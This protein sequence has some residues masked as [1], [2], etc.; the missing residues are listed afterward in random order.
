MVKAPPWT[1]RV[2]DQ[3]PYEPMSSKSK[4]ETDCRSSIE[5]AACPEHAKNDK[6]RMQPAGRSHTNYTQ[7]L[8]IVNS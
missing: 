5:V 3:I 7:Y 6:V 4:A 1:R 8:F 2:G